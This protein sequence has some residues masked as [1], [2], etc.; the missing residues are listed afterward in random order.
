M[1]TLANEWKEAV[2]PTVP[3]TLPK[4]PPLTIRT[5]GEIVEMRFDDA[6]LILANGYL[7]LGERTAVC[8]MG[9][10]GKSAGNR[11]KLCYGRWAGSRM[12]RRHRGRALRSGAL[13]RGRS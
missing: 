7:T 5:V 12:L 13:R 3:E 2:A 6:E 10:V 9:G 8:G 4:R 11:S 1:T